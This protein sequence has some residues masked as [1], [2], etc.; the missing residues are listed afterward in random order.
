MDHDEALT[1]L[2]SLIGADTQSDVEH[3]RSLLQ[4]TD[5]NV[6]A[7]VNLHFASGPVES[8]APPSSA[9]PVAGD[10]YADLTQF[11]HLGTTTIRG[12]RDSASLSGG[13]PEGPSEVPSVP[14][15][16][17]GP[18]YLGCSLVT[19]QPPCS[20]TEHAEACQPSNPGCDT[21][22]SSMSRPR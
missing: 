16:Q 19:H 21:S 8:N 1:M 13:G 20:F 10:P 11:D 18:S 22:C 3:A 15:T 4:V 9:Q 12:R 7:A 2:T 17:S 6:E 14:A 5:Y